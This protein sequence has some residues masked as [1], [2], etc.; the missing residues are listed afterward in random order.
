MNNNFYDIPVSSYL[1]IVVLRD[2]VNEG[3]VD[4]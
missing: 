2:E 4:G 3:W 1:S